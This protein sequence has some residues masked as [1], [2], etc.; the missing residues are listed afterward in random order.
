MDLGDWLSAKKTS[1][2]KWREGLPKMFQAEVSRETIRRAANGLPISRKK[3]EPISQA[4]GGEVEV[5]RLVLGSDDAR[6]AARDILRE[7]TTPQGTAGG[8]AGKQERA[9]PAGKGAPQGSRKTERGDRVG[10]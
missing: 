6:V 2:E 8:A 3:A 4:T 9:A 5:W 1:G 7:A 10:G